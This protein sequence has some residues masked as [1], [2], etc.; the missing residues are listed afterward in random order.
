MA[1]NNRTNPR[2]QITLGYDEEMIQAA[3]NKEFLIRRDQNLLTEMIN[4]LM[5]PRPS[6]KTISV[7]DFMPRLEQTENKTDKVDNPPA[8]DEARGDSL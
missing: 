2:N 6:F 4:R 1:R 3:K 5:R 8:R 7:A